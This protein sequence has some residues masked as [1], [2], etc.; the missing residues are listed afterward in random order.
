MERDDDKKP[1]SNQLDRRIT[2]T[3]SR[4]S[5]ATTLTDSQLKCYK[6][7]KIFEAIIPEE[8]KLLWIDCVKES[9]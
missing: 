3:M 5:E 6:H 9:K 1:G 4:I 8:N 2:G 7:N